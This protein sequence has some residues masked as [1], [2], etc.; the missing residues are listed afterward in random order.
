MSV[1]DSFT[2][3][4]G[5]RIDLLDDGMIHVSGNGMDETLHADQASSAQ[6]WYDQNAYAFIPLPHAIAAFVDAA[7]EAGQAMADAAS[8]ATPSVAEPSD[9]ARF[10]SAA[11]IAFMKAA[12][13]SV[14]FGIGAQLLELGSAIVARAGGAGGAGGA[15]EGQLSSAWGGLDDA[16]DFYA[17]AQNAQQD[18]AINESGQAVLQ[19]FAGQADQV[20]QAIQA[21]LGG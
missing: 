6:Q 10:A 20:G 4:D 1:T 13:A 17:L 16:I 9:V 19:S 8:L 5:Y 11:G 21:L 15:Q 12:E 2:D 14:P 18:R 7:H 3:S